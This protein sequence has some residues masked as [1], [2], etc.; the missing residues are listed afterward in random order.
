MSQADGRR[1]LF[2]V[3]GHGFGH[4]RRTC[5][6]IEALR[7]RDPSIHISIRSNAPR[8]I[9]ESIG[10]DGSKIEN[11]PLDI[12]VVEK[13]AFTVDAIATAKNA[14]ELWRRHEAIVD[15]ELQAVSE[16]APALNV[17]DIPFLAGEIGHR[18]GVPCI[19][20]G[21]FTWDWIFEPMLR[22]PAEGADVLHSMAKGYAKMAG[23]LRHPFSHV[24]SQFPNVWDISAVGYAVRDRD[25]ILRTLGFDG[26]EKRPTVLLAMRGGVAWPTVLA[27]VQK[28]PEFRFSTFG[29]FS[30]PGPANLRCIQANGLDFA[31]IMAGHDVTISK[32]GSGL[33]GD[34]LAAQ[35]RILWPRRTGFREDELFD[36]AAREFLN[37]QEI[38]REDYVTGNWR[39]SLE[40][41][42][43]QPRPAKVMATD[44]ADQ[45][46]ERIL[47]LL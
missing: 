38:G 36:P 8:H 15:S 25:F 16:I 45:A 34:A 6:I 39:S 40:T 1:I 10:F 43:R 35:A 19:A 7:R 26:G 18:L 32:L 11:S 9:F 33:V 29:T 28:C 30:E 21:N 23:V 22:D 2:Y 46:A 13:D 41:L 14:V 47:T 37:L 20:S 42:L 27:G 4:A 24:M 17:S 12:A 31:E 3:T 5:R 44:G